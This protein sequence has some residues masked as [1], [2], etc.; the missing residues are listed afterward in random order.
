VRQV[1]YLRILQLQV[2]TVEVGMN[3]AAACGLQI[4][5]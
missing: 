2:S 4:G 3:F 1:Y 5:A